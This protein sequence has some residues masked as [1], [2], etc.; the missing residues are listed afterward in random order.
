MQPQ[1]PDGRIMPVPLLFI[2]TSGG[3][4]RRGRVFQADG[5]VAGD[6][7]DL[8]LDVPPAW[9]PYPWMT[10]FSQASATAS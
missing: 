3:I 1:A 10:M 7:G 2:G 5:Q 4:E 6:G 8:N 9:R